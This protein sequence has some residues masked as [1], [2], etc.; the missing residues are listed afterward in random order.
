[1][2]IAR[3]A[4]AP[5]RPSRALLYSHDTFGLG[6]LRRNLKIASHLLGE[7]PGLRVVLMT[8]SPVA[9]RFEMPERLSVVTLPP[10]VKVGSEQYRSRDPRFGTALV[11]RARSAIMAD[12]ARRFLPEVFLVDHSPAGMGGELLPVFDAL[13]ER[14]PSTRI[15][16]GLRDVL[17]EASAVRQVWTDQ[18]IYDLLSTV[19]DRVLV[20]GSREVNDVVSSYDIPSGVAERLTYCG[21]INDTPAGR[22]AG[23]SAH[24]HGPAHGFQPGER[25]I[26]GTTGG[27][28][29]G[30]FILKAAAEA[31]ARVGMG[32][33]LVA[34]PFMPEASLEELRGQAEG[35]R[36]AGCHV[37]V[38]SFLAD[39]AGAVAE[40]TAV[41]SMGGYN[42]LVELAAQ[43]KPTVVV[44]RTEPRREQEIRGEMFSR[45]GLVELVRPGPDLPARL[46]VALD[47]AVRPGAAHGVEGRL[48]P[49]GQEA[50]P[51]VDLGGLARVAA[52]VAEMAGA[53]ASG[54]PAALAHARGPAYARDRSAEA[55]DSLAVPA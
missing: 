26:L 6:H 5:S 4:Q 18:G 8:G 20:Y 35:L 41:V 51:G 27:G 1:M 31:A 7:E 49:V 19:Y 48:G 24:G 40:A 14:S 25:F 13:A 33:L 21:Y 3:R 34:G 9:D 16:L 42:S 37:E 10:V 50:S 28:G 36:A 43:R 38:V 29:D 23:G 39:L 44:P 54:T 11:R 17:D 47:R 46:A 12:V 52:V 32:A 2:T 22:P 53:A 15:V 55:L 45:L 30:A